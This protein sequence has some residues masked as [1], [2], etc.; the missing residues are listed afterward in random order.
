M[1]DA[2]SSEPSTPPEEEGLQVGE[3]GSGSCSPQPSPPPATPTRGGQRAGPAAPGH[4]RDKLD[5][6]AVLVTKFQSN[7][8]LDSVDTVIHQVHENIRRID[9][10]ISE[11]VQN[12]KSLGSHIDETKTLIHTVVENVT[13]L[14]QLS[15]DA[16]DQSRVTAGQA[17]YAAASGMEKA[18]D[19]LVFLRELRVSMDTCKRHRMTG[20]YSSIHPLLEKQA[21]LVPCFASY[22]HVPVVAQL[23]DEV[24]DFQEELLTDISNEFKVSYGKVESDKDMMGHLAESAKLM[25][26]IG[27]YAANDLIKWFVD[28]KREQLQYFILHARGDDWQR[29]DEEEREAAVNESVP[30]SLSDLEARFSWLEEEVD[31][32]TDGYLDVF[33]ATWEVAETFTHACCT[34]LRGSI[35][36]AILL[37]SPVEVEL[38]VSL[39][40]PGSA[41]SSERAPCLTWVLLSG[42]SKANDRAGGISCRSIRRYSR[43]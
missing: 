15:V 8:S 32:Y 23:L 1:D 10:E 20:Q 6:M 38:Q 37:S 33:P 39:L 13:Q 16:V 22:K 18:L 4:R 14:R 42:L 41:G 21:E 27:E 19:C 11:Q 26:A 2:P 29:L 35:E 9:Q 43:R 12:S 36:S 7:E 25:D 40:A 17:Q 5:P 28:K 30:K 24:E 34:Q 31:H 3:E